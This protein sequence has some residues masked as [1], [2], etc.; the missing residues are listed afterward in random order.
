VDALVDLAGELL[1]ATHGVAHVAK[2]AETEADRQV[3]ASAIRERKE[4]L[5]RVAVAIHEAALQLRMVPVAQVFRSF[6]RAVRDLAQQLGKDVTFV[7]LGE[8][9]EADKTIADQMFEPIMHLIRNALDHGIEPVD[10]RSL[11]GK[12]RRGR[13]TL[14]AAARGRDVV[15]T[16]ADDGRGLDPDALVSSAR[17]KGLL[18][19]DAPAPAE[20]SDLIFQPGFSTAK[21]VSELSGRGVGLDVVRAKIT[22]QKGIV[23]VR[24]SAGR[25]TVFEVVVPMTVAVVESLLVR[26][27]RRFFAFPTSGIVRASSVDE[28]SVETRGGRELMRDEQGLLTLASLEGLL[29]IPAAPPR[30]PRT[31]VVAEQGNRRAGFVVEAIEGLR[32][33]VIKPLPDSIRRA[34]EVTGTAELPDGELALTL[35]TGLLLARAVRAEVFV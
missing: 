18:A 7:T 9:T 32:D 34:P 3:L 35:D 14:T 23:T 15:L 1:I 31:I 24:S 21:E 4:A 27:G 6:P 26:A 22:A 28:A 20:P 5:E 30:E 8:T 17:E 19:P 33:L 25:G 2:R 29:G 12:P 10:E 13:V 11:L 16:L